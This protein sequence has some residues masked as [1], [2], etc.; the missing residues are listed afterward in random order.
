MKHSRVIILL[1]FPFLVLMSVRGNAQQSKKDSLMNVFSRSKEDTNKVNTL[2]ALSK[3]MA[4]SN[5]DS[6]FLF[7]G[8]ALSL[9]EKLNFVNG[10]YKC[11]K[12]NGWLYTKN[13][14]YD[15]AINNYAAA[16]EIAGKLKNKKQVAEIL[17]TTGIAYRMQAK[18]PQALSCYFKALKIEEENKNEQGVA[19]NLINIGVV[20]RHLSEPLKAEAHYLKALAVSKK[21]NDSNFIS[22]IV[23]NIGNLYYSR[24]MKAK[25]PSIKKPLLDKT[26]EYYFNA[27][28]LKTKLNNASEVALTLSNIGSVYHAYAEV[29]EPEQKKYYFEKTLKYLM[30]G[31]HASENLG[32]KSSFAFDYC[33]I[34]TVLMNYGNLDLNNR[35]TY[36][37]K[38]EKYLNT[39]LKLSTASGERETIMETR[40]SLFQIDSARNNWASAFIHYSKYIAARDSINNEENTKKETQLEMQFEFDKKQAADSVKV[41]EEKKVAA[42]VL[43]AEKNKSYSLYGGLGIVLI[44]SGFLF[45]RFRVIQKQ[46]KVIE[47]QKVIVEEQKTIVEEKQKEIVDSIRYAKRIQLAMMASEKNIDKILNKMMS[48]DG[49]N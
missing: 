10:I 44:F 9:A 3:E 33:T 41:V 2:V 45:N 20:Y 47:D 36:H 18:F 39:A 35:K 23:G 38:A 34:G 48:K 1:F 32:S 12:F 6:S 31:L 14:N 28:E 17:L 46:K 25:D 29:V 13:A 16:L 15:E 7:S 24:A 21:I 40:N 11:R 27:L 37:E 30:D 5:I 19:R 8:K 22:L 26:L 49:K 4:K 43:R 42:A